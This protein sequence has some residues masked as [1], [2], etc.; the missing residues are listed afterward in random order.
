MIIIMNQESLVAL[1]KVKEVIQLCHALLGIQAH[2]HTVCHLWHLQY[3]QYK[4]VIIME[5]AKLIL[6]GQEHEFPIITG[7]EGEGGLG[8][9]QHNATV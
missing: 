2:H 6:D 8:K 5:T 4:G 3:I 9:Q 1:K 7:T